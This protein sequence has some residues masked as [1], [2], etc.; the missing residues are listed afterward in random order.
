MAALSLQIRNS[1]EIPADV[2]GEILV[3]LLFFVENIGVVFVMEQGVEPLVAHT[4]QIGVALPVIHGPES[5]DQIVIITGA[6]TDGAVD[7][8]QQSIELV[9]AGF[10]MDAVDDGEQ[11]LETGTPQYPENIIHGNSLQCSAKL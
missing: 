9:L 4:G 10:L 11:F 7:D 8:I 2:V 3:E 1:P 5:E 6:V